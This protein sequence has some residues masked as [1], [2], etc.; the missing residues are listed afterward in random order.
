MKNPKLRILNYLIP[1]VGLIIAAVCYFRLPGQ[2]TMSWDIN[3]VPSYEEKWHLFLMS[4]VG[5]A[6][7]VLFDLLPHIDPRRKNYGKFEHFYDQFCIFMQLF[8][9]FITVIVLA[10]NFHPGTVN[11]PL[12]VVLAVG[13]LFLFIGNELPKVK[14]NFFMGIRT[15]WALCSEENWRRTHRLGGKCIFTAGI[16]II[17]TAWI[18]NQELV[19]GIMLALILVSCLV[20]T[21]MSYLWY[22]RGI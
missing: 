13:V 2:I 11:I 14:S 20:P 5:V 6:M 4:G 8:L 10:E 18:P 12:V 7:A 1:V 16:L 3:G 21:L 22:R 9:F 17:L 15:P 19:F